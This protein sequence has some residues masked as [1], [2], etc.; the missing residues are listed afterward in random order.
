MVVWCVAGVYLC[1]SV[2]VCESVHC[3]VGCGIASVVCL[4]GG[5]SVCVVCVTDVWVHCPLVCESAVAC[6]VCGGV[7]V[8]VCGCVCMCVCT[9]V[10]SCVH[11][12]LLCG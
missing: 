10:A 9:C 3:V 1:G 5:L 4:S 12:G 11:D 8:C 2:S 7:C 6:G